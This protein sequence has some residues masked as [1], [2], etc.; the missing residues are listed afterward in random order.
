MLHA[1]AAPKSLSGTDRDQEPGRH[2]DEL[3]RRLLKWAVFF[4]VTLAGTALYV[5][6]FGSGEHGSDAVIAIHGGDTSSAA[7]PQS[8]NEMTAA[9]RDTNA[10]IRT[11]LHP[12]PRP[13]QA[14]FQAALVVALASL[15][16]YT[17]LV[18]AL[19]K[20]MR[21]RT[22]SFALPFLRGRRRLFLRRVEL[23]PL[24]HLA[25]HRHA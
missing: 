9:L 1:Q 8:L 5:S 10:Y 19:A 11:N 7:S 12:A 14:V 25:G 13:V 16:F 23:T 20:Q 21:T 6:F 3:S 18:V 2:D 17:F 15:W 4:I 24:K 22:S